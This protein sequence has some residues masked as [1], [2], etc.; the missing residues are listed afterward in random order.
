M[1]NILNNKTFIIPFI[2]LIFITIIV[3]NNFINVDEE[4]ITEIITSQCEAQNRTCIV[5]VDDLKIKVLFEKNIYYLKP[6]SLSLWTESHGDLK[7]KSVSVDFKM[8]NMNMG[9]NRFKLK[10]NKLAHWQGKA[11]L[12]ICVTGRADWFSEIDIL[13]SK[14]R[15]RF[16][17]P[18]IVQKIPT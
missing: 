7:V 12:P 9:V 11:L 3:F 5:T 16:I 17:F 4:N 18:I 8:K 6:F 15:Y 2:L 14:G 10:R 1:M 13:T